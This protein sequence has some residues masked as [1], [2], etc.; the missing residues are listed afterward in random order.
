M[1]MIT[2]IILP[3]FDISKRTNELEINTKID[4]ALVILVYDF[5]QTC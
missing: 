4:I 5:T 2:S 3:P 1:M